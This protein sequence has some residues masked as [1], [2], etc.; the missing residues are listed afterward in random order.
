[1]AARV[2]VPPDAPASAAAQAVYGR[3]PE[4]CR[5][6]AT[7]TPTADSDIKVEVWLPLTA[8]NGR[9]QAVGNG[10]SP[11][12]SLRR[13]GAALFDGFAAAGTD[14]GH[15]GNDADFALGHHEKLVDFAYR[16]VHEMTVAAKRADRRALRPGA[17]VLV[18][19]RLLAGW[20]SGHHQCAALSG[21]FRRHRGRRGRLGHDA[22]SRRAAGP[23]PGDE[24]HARRGDSAGKI[25]G[26]APGRS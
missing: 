19:H 15:A 25:S 2:F 9:L 12:R 5:V 18:F 3:L 7:L 17:P 26:A 8:W 23:E 21:G 10:G 4:F 6:Q 14:T 11:A 13:D 1:V 16:A 20:A 24:P 22:R